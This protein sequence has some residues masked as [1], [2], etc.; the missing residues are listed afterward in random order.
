MRSG[1]VMDR[2]ER[3]RV[4]WGALAIAVA[5]LGSPGLSQDGLDGLVR[6]AREAWL[7]HDIATLL[8][9]SDTV[10]LQVPGIPASNALR[11]GQAARLLDRY[12]ETAQERAFEVVDLRRLSD[13]HA[14]AELARN[15]VVRGTDEIR[16]ETVFLGFRRVEGDWRLREV[17]VMR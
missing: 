14:Y 3:Q 11:P 15:Y 12:L 5:F 7:R 16:R 17:R 1:G 2:I 8:S 4:S 10:R 13:D 6:E 9:T